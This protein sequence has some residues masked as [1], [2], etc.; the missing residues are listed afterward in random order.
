MSAVFQIKHEIIHA[1]VVEIKNSDY[2]AKWIS[3]GTLHFHNSSVAVAYCDG[4]II[5]GALSISISTI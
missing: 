2:F 3:V 4:F 5:N 1:I